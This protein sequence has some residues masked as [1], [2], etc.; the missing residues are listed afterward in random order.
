[1]FT[2]ATAMQRVQEQLEAIA[3]TGAAPLMTFT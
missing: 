3:R 1:M 2:L